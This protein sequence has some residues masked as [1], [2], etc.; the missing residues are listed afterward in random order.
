M[1]EMHFSGDDQSPLVPIPV[2]NEVGLVW[3][4]TLI[5]C[6]AAYSQLAGVDG[7]CPTIASWYWAPHTLTGSAPVRVAQRRNQLNEVHT[8]SY[9]EITSYYMLVPERSIP[10]PQVPRWR[11]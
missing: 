7:L 2:A 8:V 10:S 11:I 4:A 9:T 6:Y 3:R 5:S 1:A